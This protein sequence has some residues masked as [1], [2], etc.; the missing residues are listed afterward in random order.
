MYRWLVRL[1]VRRSLRL[2]QAGDIDR[3]LKGYADDVRFVFHGNNSWAGEF[4][5]KEAIRPWLER[6]HRVGLRLEVHDVV[7]SGPLWNTTGCLL[8]TDHAR[9]PDGEVVYRNRGVIYGKIAWG[10]IKHYEVFEDTEKVA[11]F[12]RYLETR[13][14]AGT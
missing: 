10:K 12:D 9:R 2:H 6:F 7:V 3:L 14:P 13:E 1:M 11:E 5:G 4:R 8:F